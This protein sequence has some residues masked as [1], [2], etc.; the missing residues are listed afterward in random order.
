MSFLA[1]KPKIN[2]PAPEPP[3][4]VAGADSLT[5]GSGSDARTQ[6]A[7]GRLKLSTRRPS[8]I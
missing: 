1:P 5:V 3:A 2:P 7:V 6:G 4:P 8:A